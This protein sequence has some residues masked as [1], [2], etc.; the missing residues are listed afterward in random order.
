MTADDPKAKKIWHDVPYA[1]YEQIRLNGNFRQ[2]FSSTHA[3]L[4]R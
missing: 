3:I 1:Q 4:C 2:Y